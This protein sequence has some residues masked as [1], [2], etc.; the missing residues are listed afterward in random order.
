[1]RK[2]KD[3]RPSQQS[4]L[5]VAAQ[6]Q[7]AP[8]PSEPLQFPARVTLATAAMPHG[9]TAAARARGRGLQPG[10]KFSRTLIQD[11]RGR[12]YGRGTASGLVAM[13]C[14]DSSGATK[15]EVGLSNF[16]DSSLL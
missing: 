5:F 11:A 10:S 8:S 6:N 12:S 1:M 2:G 13:G 4:M 9:M 15:F 3:G 14:Q 16:E 7:K